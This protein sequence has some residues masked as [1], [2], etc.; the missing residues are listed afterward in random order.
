MFY[1]VGVEGADFEKLRTISVRD[2]LKLKGLQFK[3]LFQM[4]VCVT[5]ICLQIETRR[6]YSARKSDSAQRMGDN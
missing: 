2:P 3:E 1:A 4:A 6:G 5:L